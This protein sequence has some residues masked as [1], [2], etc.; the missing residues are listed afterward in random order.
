MILCLTAFTQKLI[1]AFT[2]HIP[3]RPLFSSSPAFLSGYRI[4]PKYWDSLL[5]LTILVL[6]LYH[7]LGRFIRWQIDGVFLIFSKKQSLIF[8]A[9]GLKPYFLETK[10]SKHFS[11]DIFSKILSKSIYF[12]LIC[13][14]LLD[15]R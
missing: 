2:V 15:K 13:L 3:L 14:K 5:L 10:V 11:A 4:Y 12:L 6:N 1:W 8:H 9:K 7:P